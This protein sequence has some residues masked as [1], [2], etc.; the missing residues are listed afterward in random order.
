MRV[1]AAIGELPSTLKKYGTLAKQT[2]F[3]TV[4]ICKLIIVNFSSATNHKSLVLIVRQF[5]ILNNEYESC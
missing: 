3:S 4:Q 1:E 5:K 2:I